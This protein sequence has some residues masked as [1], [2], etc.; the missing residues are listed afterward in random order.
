MESPTHYFIL[1]SLRYVWNY[2]IDYFNNNIDKV[3][4]W[5]F[6]Q[7]TKLET[8]IFF[9]LTPLNRHSSGPKST[10]AVTADALKRA[11]V[12]DFM[13]IVSTSNASLSTVATWF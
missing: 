11:W 1:N 4:Y 8:I 12:K 5:W 10:W 7:W 13:N 6:E 3:S 9:D 2:H